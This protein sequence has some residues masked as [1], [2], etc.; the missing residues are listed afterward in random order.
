MGEG[1]P[2]Y[3]VVAHTWNDGKIDYF[4]VLDSKALTTRDVE[5]GKAPKWLRE[6]VAMLRLCNVS[7]EGEIIGRRFTEHLIYV[8]LS[9]QEYKELI[10]LSNQG[11][12]NEV[13]NQR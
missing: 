5:G 3:V 4:N 6:R 10:K 9:K 1:E 12:Q 7:D 2:Q 13:V 8:Y 11:V